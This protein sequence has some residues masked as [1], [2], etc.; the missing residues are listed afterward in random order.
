MY[1]GEDVETQ[2]GPIK[3]KIEIELEP[4]NV[5]RMDRVSLSRPRKSH[6]PG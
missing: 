6:W 3:E 4:D 2:D 5:D 1:P